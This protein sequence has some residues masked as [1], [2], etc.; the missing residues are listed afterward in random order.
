MSAAASATPVVSEPPRPS[1]V[2][3]PLSSM[4]W[5]PATTT[6][7]P[8][9][10]SRRMFVL[11]DREDAGLGVGV[12]GEDAHLEAGVA[13]RLDA[14]PV[15][16][17]GEEPD[18][19]L[20]A[21]GGDD[22]DLA[23]IRIGVQLLREREEAVRLAGHGRDHDDD[24]V[25]FLHEPLD[26]ARDLADALGAAHGGAAV[27]LDDEGHGETC[28]RDGRKRAYFTPAPGIVHRTIRGRDPIAVPDTGADTP[29]ACRSRARAGPP[30]RRSSRASR[31]ACRGRRP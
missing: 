31:A 26:P 2:M 16:R 23:R 9:A 30:R 28:F 19:D 13:L 3:L 6:T 7:L 1:V 27:L 20:L 18:G 10:R 22:V 25:A 17:E 11:V 15:Q 21:R 14:Q 12:V 5:K 24:L 4:P 8:V 29:S